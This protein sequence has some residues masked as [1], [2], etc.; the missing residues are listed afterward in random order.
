[1]E[2]PLH[3]PASAYRTMPWKNG[4]GATDEVWLWPPRG[5]RDA[6]SIRISRAPILTDGGFS[7]FAGADR[8]ITLIEGAGLVLDFGSR[9]EHLAPLAPFRFDTGLA[10]VGRPVG[11]PVRVF[12]VMADRD[13]WTIARAAVLEKGMDEAAGLTVLFALEPQQ[14]ETGG[15]LHDLA[16][17]DTLICGPG[18]L[19]RGG[20][21]LVVA[22]AP[23]G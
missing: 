11:G 12:N 20:R 2:L 8:V 15:R 10:P 19:R 21:A 7:A 5:D 4:T 17:Q 6:F 16:R 3:L 13:A 14:A 23:A 22:L 1:M 18:P 9:S